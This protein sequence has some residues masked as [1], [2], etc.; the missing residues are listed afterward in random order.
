[1]IM[2]NNNACESVLEIPVSALCHKGDYWAMTMIV[3]SVSFGTRLAS[4]MVSQLSRVYSRL[5]SR[6]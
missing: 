3:H 6:R 5:P 1:M 4:V 2:T